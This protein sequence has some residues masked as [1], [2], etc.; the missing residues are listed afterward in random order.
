MAELLEDFKT[1]M[2]DDTAPE[3]YIQGVAGTGKTTGL[4]EILI[5]CQSMRYVTVTC[6]YTHKA[7][8]VLSSKL[9]PITTT[10]LICTL[11]SYL[12][13][14]PT[15]NDTATKVS[16]VEGNT[17][18]EIPDSVDVIFVDEFSMIG[19]KDY[20]DLKALQYDEDGKLLVKIVYI[21]DRNQLPPV[22]DQQT[23][24]PHGDHVHTLTKI[25]RQADGN[26]LIDTLLDI[27][28]YINGKPAEA[29]AEHSNFKRNTDIVEGYKNCKTSK[30]LL[31]Y[32]NAR[33]ETLNA[34]IQGYSKPLKDDLLFSPTLRKF[35]NLGDTLLQTNNIINIMGDIVELDS[36]YKTLETLHDIAG[37]K[38]YELIDTDGNEFCFA[39][40]F[41]HEGYLQVS[42]DL[43]GEAVKI[44]NRILNQ[45]NTDAKSWA[46]SNWQHPLAK[47][48]A[49]A[50]RYYLAFKTNVIC[51]DF[52]H[53]MT[54]HK[55]QGSTYDNVFLDMNDIGKCANNDYQLYLKLLYVAIS[56]ASDT[57]YT[58]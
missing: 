26:K 20:V 31:A 18:L 13:K 38:F 43:A 25:Y 27:N 17:Q 46:K 30:I 44:N 3:M 12:K 52:P 1:F 21:G 28:D 49:K 14:R 57:V 45:F 9:P 5:Y 54:I 36:K 50:W 11:H 39:A 42:R 48:R 34:N 47:E 37:I 41:G 29:L 4:G 32:T 24:V 56:R 19:E 40:V 55:S 7:V 53:A 35:F 23:I 33:V 10:H 15:I 16:H 22:K 51:L 6:A 2:A 58:N 8:K